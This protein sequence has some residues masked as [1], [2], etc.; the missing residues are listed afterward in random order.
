MDTLPA[1]TSHRI[2]DDTMSVLQTHIILDDTMSVVKTSAHSLH[3]QRSLYTLLFPFGLGTLIL[4][5]FPVVLTIG[6]GW[7]ESW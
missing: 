7:H 2:L 4:V 3:R 5:I 6:C 1:L